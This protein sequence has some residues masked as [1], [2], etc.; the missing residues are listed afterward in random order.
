LSAV[1]VKEFHKN[2]GTSVFQ[3]ATDTP[4]SQPTKYV[5]P[6]ASNPI[7]S[8][9]KPVK[10]GPRAVKIDRRAPTPNSARQLTAALAVQAVEPWVK[11]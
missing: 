4:N 7:P 10:I 6:D 11:M 2:L 9:R 1:T 5:I 3:P 8:I